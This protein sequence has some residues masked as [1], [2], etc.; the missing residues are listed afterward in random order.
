MALNKL[1]HLQDVSKVFPDGRANGLL[2]A[3]SI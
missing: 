3:I 1:L 2:C